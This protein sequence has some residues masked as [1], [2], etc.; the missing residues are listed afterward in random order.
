MADHLP[1]GGPAVGQGNLVQ[2]YLYDVS[3]EHGFSSY[4]T[5]GIIHPDAPP[6][7]FQRNIAVF[8]PLVYHKRESLQSGERGFFL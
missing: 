8:F 1:L 4:L 2:L 5:L 3:L 7:E 6:E